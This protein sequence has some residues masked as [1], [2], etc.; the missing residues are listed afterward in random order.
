MPSPGE[1][2]RRQVKDLQF[3]RP[4]RDLN[5]CRWLEKPVSL[6]KLDDGDASEPWRI[7]TSDPQIK[8]LLLCQLS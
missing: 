8:S 1:A 3:K 5:P 7:R 2:R 6:T 4:R